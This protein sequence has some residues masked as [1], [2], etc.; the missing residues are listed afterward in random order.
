MTR[1]KG[2]GYLR[3]CALDADAVLR[4]GGLLAARRGAAAAT[5]DFAV[6]AFA[7]GVGA[8]RRAAV[9]AFAG[10]VADLAAAGLSRRTAAD[11]DACGSRT[12]AGF[13]SAGVVRARGSGVADGDRC[14]AVKRI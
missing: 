2:T 10:D 6:R 13:G 9:L 14:T 12:R 4:A 8:T 5:R 11:A 3:F 1:R 7:A